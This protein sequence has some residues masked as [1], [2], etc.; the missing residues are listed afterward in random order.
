MLEFWYAFKNCAEFTN[1]FLRTCWHGFGM[2]KQAGEYLTV[3]QVG[4]LLQLDR[5]D[6]EAMVR[7]GLIPHTR[8]SRFIVRFN[9]RD[10]IVWLRGR[11]LSATDA[12]IAREMQKTADRLE[13]QYERMARDF[14]VI[15]F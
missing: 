3:K 15:P 4:E 5:R 12:M 6:I 11:S 7:G 8:L 14:S 9:I 10:L 13:F 2:V 1:E